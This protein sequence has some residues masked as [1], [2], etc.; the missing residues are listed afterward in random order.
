MLFIVLHHFLPPL[1]LGEYFEL[2][3]RLVLALGHA[4]SQQVLLDALRLLV[5][6]VKLGLLV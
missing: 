1:F 3:L 6:G 5:D 2:G 4:L